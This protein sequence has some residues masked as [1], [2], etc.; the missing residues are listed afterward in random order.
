[1][2]VLAIES[3]AVRVEIDPAYG[4]RVL[5]LVD[6]RSGR[7]WLAKGPQSTQTGE[8]AVYLSDEAVGWDECFPT[9]SPWDA[10]AT[11]LGRPLRDHGDLWGRPW[12][13]DAHAADSLNTSRAAGA[14]Q[15]S[16]RL[17][18]RGAA[19]TADYA[20]ANTGADA[21][22]FMW[23]LHG[24]LAVTPADRIELDGVARVA[25][26]YISDGGTTIS[27][28]TCLAGAGLGRR[29][30]IPCAASRRASPPSSTPATSRRRAPRWVAAMA[31]SIWPG[32]IRRCAISG[33]G[34]T[35]AA[36]PRRARSTTWRSSRPPP[37]SITSARRWPG[38]R[39]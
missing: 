39:R 23:A 12:A 33:S 27:A 37:P 13:V 34:S 14:F 28:R 17:S 9:V 25:A 32:M 3:D 31:G 1:M 11:A 5:S 2:S 21:L 29:P 8:D 16:R 38:A 24:L 20:V 19:L 26:T 15:F 30:S 6:R 35:M 22:P 18:L 10:S 36:G 7:D 4:A